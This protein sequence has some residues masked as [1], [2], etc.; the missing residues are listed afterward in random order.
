MA[1]LKPANLEKRGLF[2]WWRFMGI[3]TYGGRMRGLARI[4]GLIFGLCFIIPSI[5]G[6]LRSSFRLRPT[7]ISRFRPLFG[8]WWA[9]LG[10][11]AGSGSGEK[12]TKASHSAPGESR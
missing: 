5:L 7:E 4:F 3:A 10:P 8:A 6:A 9:F 11:H 2:D 12:L 1:G